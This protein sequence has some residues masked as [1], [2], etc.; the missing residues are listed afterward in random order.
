MTVHGGHLG[1]ARPGIAAESG[2][3]SPLVFEISGMDCAD[4]ARGIERTVRHVPGVASSTVSFGT[5]RL[6]VLADEETDPATLSGH[7]VRAVGEAG[8]GARILQEPATATPVPPW[9]RAWLGNTRLRAAAAAGV[10]IVLAWL[11]GRLSAVASV[12]SLLS[13]LGYQTEKISLLPLLGYAGAVLIG[14]AQIARSGFRALVRSHTLDIN[15]LMTVAVLGA[16]AINEWAEAAAVVFLFGLGEGLEGLTVD[17]ARNSI[18]SLLHLTPLEAVRKSPGGPER[19]AVEDLELHDIVIVR[20]GERIPADGLVVTGGSSVD[21]AAITGES[22][23]VAKTAGSDVYAGTINGRGY[24]EVEV[25]HRAAD[26]TLARIGR[27]IEEAQE[28]R[29]PTERFVDRFAR[30]YTPVV[31][32]AAVLV[33]LVPPLTGQPLLP[34]LYRALVLLVVSCPCALVISTPVAIVAAL[35]RAA[36]FGVLIKGGEHLEQAGSIRVVAFDKTGTLTAGRPEVVA[37]RTVSGYEP[38]ELIALAAVIEERSEHPLA[39]A[40]L[41]RREHEV[42]MGACDVHGD[43][44]H[45]HDADHIHLY[46]HDESE[47]ELAAREVSDFEAIT[48]LGARASLDGHACYVGSLSLFDELGVNTHELRGTVEQWQDEGRTVLLVGGD[49]EVYGAIAVAD[50]PRPFA[51]EAL[52]QLRQAGVHRITMLTGDNERTARS[53]ARELGVDEHRA[54][55][56]PEQKVGAVRELIAAYGRVAMVGD[57]VNDAPALAT[58]TIGVAMGA[59]GSDTAIETADIALMG[60]DLGKL[61]F[62]IGL[63]RRALRII[64]ANIAFALAVKALVIGLTLLGLTSLWLAILADT[65]ATLLVVAN[66]MRLLRYQ[67]LSGSDS[68]PDQCVAATE[69]EAATVSES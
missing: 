31:F 37:V 66:S 42:A 63:S 5:A 62:V 18:R 23:P 45:D 38:E 30:Y 15:L 52:Q 9:W 40:V 4:C 12:P 8:Y 27:L 41:H 61:A 7:V 21:Q 60:D 68:L 34:W 49:T 53:V 50:R 64:R 22:M 35:G 54:G 55:L 26:A 43:H 57:G 20:P 19:V 2:N 24:L 58:A 69:P 13:L 56:L 28:Q 1:G 29:A 46:P 51:R 33:A 25:R 11:L 67:P 6:R 32:A 47:A 3:I 39:A 14:G 48:G 17:R 44:A 59:A 65:G 10:L 16:I 36:A